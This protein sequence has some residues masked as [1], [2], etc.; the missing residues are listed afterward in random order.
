MAIIVEEENRGGGNWGSIVLWIMVFAILGIAVYYIFFK[1]PDLVEVA[2]PQNFQNA[3]QL[4]KINL[5]PQD[6]VSSPLFKS[7][8]T[9]AQPVAPVPSRRDNPFLATF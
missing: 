9:Y 8:Q 3:V 2:T 7:L 5:N 1:R 4:S 6:V